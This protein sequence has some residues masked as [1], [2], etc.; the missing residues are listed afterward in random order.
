MDRPAVKNIL[1]GLVAA[2][3]LAAMSAMA[4]QSRLNAHPDELDHVNAGRFFI[5]YWDFPAMDDPRLSNTFSNY[6]VSYLQQLDVVYFFAGKFAVVAAPLLG[7]DYLALRFFNIFLFAILMVLFLRL[8]DDRKIAF[9]PL[10][11]TPQIWYVFSYFNGDAFPMFLSF[12]MVYAVARLDPPVLPAQTGLTSP[13][14][15]LLLLLG[16][17]LGL[18]CISKQNYYVLAG[19]TL[20][21]FGVCGLAAHNIKAAARNAVLVFLVAGTLFGARWGYN[22]YVN[23]T[24]RPEVPTQ[25]AEKYADKEFKP[26]SQ[27]AGTQYWGLH[28]RDQGLSYPQLFTIWTWHI[29]TFRT[30]FGVYDYMKIYA[31]LI[32]YRYIGYTFWT[33]AGALALALVINGGPG[34][35]AGLLVF[36]V[37]AGLTVF[38]ST[39]HSWINDFQA[40]GRYLF[41]IGAMAGMILARFAKAANRTLPV[42][43]VLAAAMLA[44]SF[45]SFLWVGLPLIQK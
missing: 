1:F 27:E 23:R 7:P 12:C 5:Q 40:Q 11:I 41:P 22:I 43:S 14:T 17:L 31:P 16:V 34:G 13:Q 26:S 37:F 25:N 2:G 44:L 29:W 32:Y 28:M 24:V 38:Q 18:V 42:T 36:L 10:F 15:R 33:L 4:W 35:A 39:W 19:F 3:I 30:S 45:Y 21:F 9:L 6:G 8:P 20:A